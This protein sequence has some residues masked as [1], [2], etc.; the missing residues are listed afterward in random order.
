MSM[1]KRF[2]ILIE[3]GI[4]LALCGFYVIK[5]MIPEYREKYGSSDTFIKTKDYQNL[6][7]VEIQP[8]IH[9][10]F[11]YNHKKQIYHI[12]FFTPESRALYNRGIENHSIEDALQKSISILMER[13][14]I[15]DNTSISLTRYGESGYAEFITSFHSCMESYKVE[16]ILTEKKSTLSKLAET[17]KVEGKKDHEILRSLDFYSKEII[18]FEDYD[19]EVFSDELALEYAK[20]IYQKIDN[21]VKDKNYNSFSKDNAPYPIQMMPGDEVGV[22]YPSKKSWY[23]YENGALNAY[24]EFIKNDKNYGYCFE[25]SIDSVKKGEC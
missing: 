15:E 23:S 12:L 4:M 25:G 18:V 22:I 19:D 20:N 24:I 9:F 3:V 2:R 17:L 8:N 5:V 16:P 21:F 6:F 7:E 1:N 13:D 14:Y 10:A 11:V